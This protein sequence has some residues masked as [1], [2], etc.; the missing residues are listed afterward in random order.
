MPKQA[1]DD[2]YCDCG[3]CDICDEIADR[4]SAAYLEFSRGYESPIEETLGTALWD[5]F[6]GSIYDIG[7]QFRVKDLCRIDLVVLK[8]PIVSRSYESLDREGSSSYLSI[9]VFCDGHEFHERTK[10]QAKR[11]RS[12][13]RSLQALGIP[14][15]RFTGREIHADVDRCIREIVDLEKELKRRRQEEREFTKILLRT[16]GIKFMDDCGPFAGMRLVRP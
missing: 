6:D 15:L 5:A 12:I 10:E 7:T 8:K 3:N 16:A 1:Y 9:A 11:D 4:P 14:V 13:D 2:D